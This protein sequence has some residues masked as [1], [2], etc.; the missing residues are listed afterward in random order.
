MLTNLF[1]NSIV[2]KNNCVLKIYIY[3]CD[4]G[5]RRVWMR[6]REPVVMVRIGSARDTR[7]TP[8]QQG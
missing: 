7:I 8:E 4:E 3:K 5:E 6:F 1:K 2:D